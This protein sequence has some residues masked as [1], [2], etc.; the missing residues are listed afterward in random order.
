MPLKNPKGTAPFEIWF[1]SQDF[2][3]TSVTSS[4]KALLEA[5][6]KAGTEVGLQKATP[7]DLAALLK[8]LLVSVDVSTC[9]ED[10]GNRYFGTVTEVMLD[11]PRDK[12]NVRLL[13]QDA[14]PNFTLP[15]L[16]KSSACKETITGN[17]KTYA[18]S[19]Y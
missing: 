2:D 11:C 10:A 1:S 16:N 8:D 6:F 17:S 18:G 13:V 12:L 19:A 14:E 5:A 3:S 9:D 15:A 7:R 4:L